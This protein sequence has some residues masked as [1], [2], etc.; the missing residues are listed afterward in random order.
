M[1]PPKTDELYKP[2]FWSNEDK[3]TSARES[4]RAYIKKTEREKRA[5]EYKSSRYRGKSDS[6]KIWPDIICG[7]SVIFSGEHLHTRAQTK[8]ITRASLSLF[9]S[10]VYM[11]VTHLV[12][13]WVALDRRWVGRDRCVYCR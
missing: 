2:G 9:R 7:R 12:C 5:R 1:C 11:C 8:L 13:A 3:L 10:C 6:G 4:A